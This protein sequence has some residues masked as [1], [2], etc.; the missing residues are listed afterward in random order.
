MSRVAAQA[1]KEIA[2]RL[3]FHGL[4]ITSGC[5]LDQLLPSLSVTA[6]CMIFKTSIIGFPAS[7]GGSAGKDAI[8]MTHAHATF[9]ITAAFTCVCTV[10]DRQAKRGR[11]IDDRCRL[12][13]LV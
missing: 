9:T 3:L 1:R 4:A 12:L 6:A 7:Q 11:F 10:A 5:A 2:S 13:R 8:T